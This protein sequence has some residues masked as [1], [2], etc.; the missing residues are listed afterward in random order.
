MF[1]HDAIHDRGRALEDEFFHRVDEQLRTKLRQK[2]EREELRKQ[3]VEATGFKDEQLLDHL[4]DAGFQ[5]ATVSALVLVPVV[6]V[7]WADGSVTPQERQVVMS[8]ALQ[9]GLDNQPLAMKLVESWLHAHPPRT[10]WKLWKEYASAFREIV[11]ESVAGKLKSEIVRQCKSVAE[12]SGGTL[13]F[14]KVSAAEQEILDEI[15]AT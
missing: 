13:G 11:P 2:L 5:P 4:L 14:G 1:D 10:L 15:A 8:T 7:A 12:A 6:F 9:R 3:M